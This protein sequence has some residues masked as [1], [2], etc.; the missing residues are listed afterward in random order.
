MTISPMGMGTDAFLKVDYASLKGNENVSGGT[1]ENTIHIAQFGG[2]DFQPA[3]VHAEKDKQPQGEYAY[4][5]VFRLPPMSVCFYK[6]IRNKP[7]K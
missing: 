3:P 1:K 6:H 2:Y 5:G 7:E 4:S